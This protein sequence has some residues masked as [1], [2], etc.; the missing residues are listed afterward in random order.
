MAQVNANVLSHEGKAIGERL[1]SHAV[2]IT[3]RAL[4]TT[5]TDPQ[6]GLPAR[7]EETPGTGVAG[8]WGDQHFILSA[9]HVLVSATPTDLSLFVR[10]RGDLKTQAASEVKEQD[11]SAPIPLTDTTAVIHRSPTEDLAVVAISPTAVSRLLEFFDF[12][13][14]LS[15]DPAEGEIVAGVG[16]PVAVGLRFQHKVGPVIQGN[17][18]LSPIPF[19]GTVLPDSTGRYFGGFDPARHYLSTYEPT[20]SG[21]HPSGISGAAVWIESKEK[22]AVWSPRLKFA[23]VCTSCYQN[24]TVEQMVKASVVRQF[25]ADV[26]GPQT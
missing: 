3:N 2:G 4:V 23:G 10:E 7:E 1:W 18:V 6:T 21:T 22:K 5:G 8:R 16:Y 26:F 12:R 14:G 17:I 15:V 24:G 25:L 13:D 20:E 9:K 11:G 19:T